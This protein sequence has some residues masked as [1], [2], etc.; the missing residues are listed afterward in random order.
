MPVDTRPTTLED[1]F[2]IMSAL[3][4]SAPD[5]GNVGI[6]TLAEHIGKRV[7]RLTLQSDPDE[8]RAILD[9]IAA[10]EGAVDRLA[11]DIT[12]EDAAA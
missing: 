12:D 2:A 10:M 4:R 3:A 11:G 1:A 6:T 7:A 5:L 8:I 9:M